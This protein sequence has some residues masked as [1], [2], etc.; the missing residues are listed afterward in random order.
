MT[1]PAVVVVG[2]ACRDLD[3]SDRRG[4]RLGGAV[5]YGALTLARLGIPTAALIGADAE[6]VRAPELDLLRQSGVDVHVQPLER[7]AVFENVETPRGR[8]QSAYS[9]SDAVPAVAL[10][11]AWRGADTWLFAPVAGELD[12]GWAS[13]PPAMAFV[14]LGWQGLLR[15]LDPGQPVRHDPPRPSALLR[16]A[17]LVSVGGD[18][19]APEI[20]LP[21]LGA[22][23]RHG[24]SVVLTRSD[25]GGLLLVESGGLLRPV[26]RYPA[27]RADPR[28]PTGAGDVFLAA[29]LAARRGATAAAAT[30][31][32]TPAELRF[33]ATVAGL[34]VEGVGINGV[35]DVSAVRHRL[36]GELVARGS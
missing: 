32:P 21:A 24:A 20:D 35:P 8:V 22:L 15:T 16:R 31:A 12:D 17:H 18:D 7:G 9:V 33:A 2:A 36:R 28:D 5:T 3:R 11:P 4:W 13:V 27:A 6:A 25:A 30:P 23:L 29:L 1:P 10:P 14:G 34:A 19:L 26:R